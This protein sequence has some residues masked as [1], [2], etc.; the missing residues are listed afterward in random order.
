M[1][2]LL[3]ENLPPVLA[4]SIQALF[5][6]SKHVRSLGLKGQPDDLIW[7]YAKNHGFV[8]V[9]KDSDFNE[10]ALLKG[11]PPQVIW[12]RIGNCTRQDLQDLLLTNF[13]IIHQWEK[14][15]EESVLEL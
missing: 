6:E 1:K 7:E 13:E 12:L 5:P 4:D 9:S 15:A 8:L 10:R 11:H 14:H 2:L 3:D